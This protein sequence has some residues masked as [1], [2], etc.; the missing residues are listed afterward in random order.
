MG[1]WSK[2]IRDRLSNYRNI[3]IWANWWIQSHHTFL[4]WTPLNFLLQNI[5]IRSHVLFLNL[6]WWSWQYRYFPTI[7]L[8]LKFNTMVGLDTKVKLK[9][10]L[11]LME[12][13]FC[14]IKYWG[15]GWTVCCVLLEFYYAVFF[16]AVIMKDNRW[17]DMAEASLTW[18]S[19]IE[20]LHLIP[21]CRYILLR[22]VF[23]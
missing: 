21:T 6:L 22:F 23:C 14:I 2:S 7:N 5:N 18:H 8:R 20:S 13:P 19:D 3:V 4:T 9:S 11:L 12:W 17:V 16:L 1:S 15:I 10:F